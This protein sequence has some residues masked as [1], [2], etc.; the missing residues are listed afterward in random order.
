MPKKGLLGTLHTLLD[1]LHTLLDPLQLHHPVSAVWVCPSRACARE[2][3]AACAA[4]RGSAVRAAC[5]RTLCPT[6]A[7][8][9]PV[10]CDT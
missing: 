1:P 6:Y 5:I 3:R 9:M 8:R 2:A 4:P 10:A 7:R